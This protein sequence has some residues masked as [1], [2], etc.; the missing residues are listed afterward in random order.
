MEDL[1]YF[2]SGELRKVY[3]GNLLRSLCLKDGEGGEIQIVWVM[4]LYLVSSLD[5]HN[6]VIRGDPG[7]K[8]VIRDDQGT[9]RPLEVKQVTTRSLEV[10]QVGLSLAKQEAVSTEQGTCL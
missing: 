8:K 9:T 3:I 7:H 5:V 2:E 1:L 10:T 6:Q 4:D